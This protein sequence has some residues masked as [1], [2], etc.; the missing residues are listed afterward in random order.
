MT[1]SEQIEPV[2]LDQDLINGDPKNLHVFASVRLA[3]A[4]LSGWDHQKVMGVFFELLDCFYQWKSEFGQDPVDPNREHVG[5]LSYAPPDKEVAFPWDCGGWLVLD[6][7]DLFKRIQFAKY[8][9]MVSLVEQHSILRLYA[10]LTLHCS[11]ECERGHTH[12]EGYYAPLPCALKAGA[13]LEAEWTRMVEAGKAHDA[14]D[15]AM[16]V[17]DKL[18]NDSSRH[19]SHVKTV[20]PELGRKARSEMKKEKDEFVRKTAIEI[21]RSSKTCPKVSDL[22][23]AIYQKAQESDVSMARSSINNALKGRTKNL[24]RWVNLKR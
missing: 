7:C 5:L 19:S 8:A 14:L 1:E 16:R 2:W 12:K 9:P 17:F 3:Q 22:V 18:I 13:G 11:A 23:D 4:L 21:L 6:P 15:T 10:V 24:W 20:L